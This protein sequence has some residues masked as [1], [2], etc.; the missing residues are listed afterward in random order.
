MLP[1][2]FQEQVY[3]RPRTTLSGQDYREI[4]RDEAR[5][6]IGAYLTGTGIIKALYTTQGKNFLNSPKQEEMY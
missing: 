4:R 6:S 1:N 2:Y 3:L 5:T